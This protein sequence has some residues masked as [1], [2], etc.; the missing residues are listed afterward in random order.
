MRWRALSYVIDFSL[1]GT[2]TFEGFVFVLRGT[3]LV[4]AI[5]TTRWSLK[6]CSHEP[7]YREKITRRLRSAAHP[8]LTLTPGDKEANA[9]GIDRLDH[10]CE[11]RSVLFCR[12][13]TCPPPPLALSCCLSVRQPRRMQVV[14][15]REPVPHCRAARRSSREVGTVLFCVLVTQTPFTGPPDVSTSVPPSLTP[16][17]VD[18]FC[19]GVP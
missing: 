7:V 15:G 16:V 9:L 12:A 3:T 17:G 5:R 18:D 14:Q 1:R 6:L 11:T 2:S 10:V 13:P 8:A 4:T 19:L